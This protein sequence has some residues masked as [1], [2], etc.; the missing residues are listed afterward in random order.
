MRD[1]AART[2]AAVHSMAANRSEVNSPANHPTASVGTMAKVFVYS[3]GD[4]MLRGRQ[5]GGR[6]GA[7]RAKLTTDAAQI[8]DLGPS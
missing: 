6:P 5:H 4:H 3:T 1:G 7:A 8:S 2:P